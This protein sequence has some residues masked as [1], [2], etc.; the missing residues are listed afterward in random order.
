[1]QGYNAQTATI[2]SVSDTK[3]QRPS[4]SGTIAIQPTIPAAVFQASSNSVAPKYVKTSNTV[5]TLTFAASYVIGF[6]TGSNAGVY[7]LDSTGVPHYCLD[8]TITSVTG[9]VV[10]I[11]AP[12]TVPLGISANGSPAMT[13][14]TSVTENVTTVTVAIAT[15]ATAD[16]PANPDI[17]DY[18]IPAASVQQLLITSQ[19]LGATELFVTA[20]LSLY[21]PYFATGLFYEWSSGDAYT[22][23]TGTVTKARFYNFTLNS[24]IMSVGA[25]MA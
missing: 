14:F 1:M 7:W 10:V 24:Q 2:G 12:G 3:L 8:C 11:T 22:I 23:W 17:S 9:Q 21:W 13:D 19:G 16:T 5:L 6:T 18:T 20:T 15:I 25:L 4:G